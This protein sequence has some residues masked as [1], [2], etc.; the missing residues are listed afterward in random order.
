MRGVKAAR[1]VMI[2]VVIRVVIG[3]VGV[4]EFKIGREEVRIEIRWRRGK[5]ERRR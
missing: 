5:N 4:V 2:H 3:V 1:F